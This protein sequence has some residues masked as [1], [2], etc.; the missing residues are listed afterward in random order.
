M[1]KQSKNIKIVLKILKDEIGGDMKSALS[2]MSPD[3]SMTWVYKSKKG[4][5]F[6]Q[7]KPDFKSEM[8]DVYKIEGRKYD[9]KNIAEGKNVVMVELVESYPDPETKKSIELLSSL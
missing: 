4:T 6:P 2:K 1:N 3:Y 8:K 7:T 9:I 5:L